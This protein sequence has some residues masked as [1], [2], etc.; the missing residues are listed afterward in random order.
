MAATQTQPDVAM[1]RGKEPVCFIEPLP[2]WKHLV[3]NGRDVKV[4]FLPS[5]ARECKLENGDVSVGVMRTTVPYV[6]AV[7]IA[8]SWMTLTC[9]K[10]K[11]G[12]CV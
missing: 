3:P 7:I 8:R 10:L 12:S 4:F 6:G 2:S 5:F 9:I 11:R 1:N